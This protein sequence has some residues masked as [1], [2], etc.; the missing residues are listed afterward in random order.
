MNKFNINKLTKKCTLK[1]ITD[2]YENKIANKIF[3]AS[4]TREDLYIY[5]Y[6]YMQVKYDIFEPLFTTSFVTRAM[7]GY[8]L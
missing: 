4:N 6:I 3:D 1:Q 5:I 2:L 7:H 8:A